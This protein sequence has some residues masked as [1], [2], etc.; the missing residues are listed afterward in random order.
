MI[1]CEDRNIVLQMLWVMKIMV[2]FCL[3][4][5]LCRLVLSL[6]WVNLF[7]VLKGLF[8]SSRLGEVVSVWV[9]EV[10]ICM[11]LESLC[12]SILWNF[13]RFISFNVLVI[14]VLVCVCGMWCSFSGSFVF[15]FIVVQGIRVVFWNIMVSVCLG[16]FIVVRLLFYQ[17]MWLWDGFFSLVNIFSKVFLLQFEG[18]SSEMNL[19][20]LILSFILLSVCVL[21]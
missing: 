2:R 14:C 18:F 10:C 3:F 1:M 12:G 7:R 9:M 6:L 20:C 15:C 17:W 5:M 19:L 16:V 13:F 11:L 21:L 8:I 4:Q